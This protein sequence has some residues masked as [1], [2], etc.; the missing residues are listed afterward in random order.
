MLQSL[1]CVILVQCQLGN[2]Y[3]QK[4]NHPHVSEPI[5]K[6]KLSCNNVYVFVWT[7]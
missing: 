1:S 4:N 2:C 7:R 3:K 5:S 6:V